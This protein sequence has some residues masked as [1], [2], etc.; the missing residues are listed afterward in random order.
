M[1]EAAGAEASGVRP[2]VIGVG[3]CIA[4]TVNN[5]VRAI[6]GPVIFVSLL[7]FIITGTI[8]SL[9]SLDFLGF[10]LPASAPSTE[11]APPNVAS[12]SRSASASNSSP[13]SST[14]ASPDSQRRKRLM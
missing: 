6:R 3:L 5:T 7:P 11:I 8:G 9:A 1:A 12:D 10:G 2:L 4:I 14:S 13:N